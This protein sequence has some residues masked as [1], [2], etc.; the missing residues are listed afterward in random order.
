MNENKD[1]AQILEAGL[2]G[3]EV[4]LNGIIVPGELDALLKMTS[5]MLAADRELDLVIERGAKGDEL[6]NHLREL[7]RVKGFIREDQPGTR[8]IRITDYELL[9][10]NSDA[11]RGEK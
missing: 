11:R 8:T 10:L 9:D 6:F 2:R 3:E 5:I 4:L 7:V 1:R